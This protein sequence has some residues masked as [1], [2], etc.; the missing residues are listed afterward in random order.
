M[1]KKIVFI[2]TISNT[3]Y[4]HEFYNALQT[5]YEVHVIQLSLYSSIRQWAWI[6]NKNY[7]EYVIDFKNIDKRNKF[8]SAWK[9]YKLIKEINPIMIVSHGYN[10]FEFILIPL[11]FRNK[12]TACEISTTYEDKKRR[13]ITEF[14]KSIFVRILFNYFFTYGIA[15]FIYLN[16]FLKVP[17][18]RIVIRGNYSHIQMKEMYWQ[19]YDSRISRLLYVG[20]ISSEKNLKLLITSFS[21][22]LRI[23]GKEYL[24]SLVG[25]GPQKT[26]LE[27]I[28]KKS[29]YAKYIE[30]VEYKN[31]EDLIFYYQNSKAFVL[32]SLSE[33]WGLV[34]NEAIHFC[35]PII[36]SNKC[37]CVPDLCNGSNSK[38]FDPTD[39]EELTNIFCDILL[40]DSSL[41]KMSNASIEKAIEHSP[42]NVIKR[43]KLAF[44]SILENQS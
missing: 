37:G 14:F 5:E 1:K 17:A 33:P 10:R 42:V 7:K 2:H 30:F 20:R 21:A 44:A 16:K 41:Q 8:T 15:S 3:P 34:I 32:P 4:K 35:L 24:L 12:I 9:I 39:S 11:I 19:D 40:D 6:D 43:L 23:S 13:K 29:G 25:S 26:E 28:V 36:I 27:E 31:P 18:D 22:F 38:I